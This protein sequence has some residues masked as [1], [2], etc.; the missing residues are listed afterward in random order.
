[1][2]RV[3]CESARITSIFPPLRMR[4]FFTFTNRPMGNA[5]ALRVFF[6]LGM[7]AF[8]LRGFLSLDRLPFP[9]WELVFFLGVLFL[10]GLSSGRLPFFGGPALLYRLALLH[11]L[12][13]RG[14]LFPRAK[15]AP[16]NAPFDRTQDLDCH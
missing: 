14:F 12:P 4:T 7:L 6:F 15:R 9:S 13:L 11:S 3:I 8:P 5:D 10:Y 1:M 16:L 2:P